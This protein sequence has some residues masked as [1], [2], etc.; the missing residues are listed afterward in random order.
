MEGALR[1]F[2]IEAFSIALDDLLLDFSK[3]VVTVETTALLENLARAARV[4][5]R[6]AAMFAGEKI[7][8]TEERA[9]LH[10]ALR[11]RS[12]RPVLVDGA[13]VMGDVRAVA[14]HAEKCTLFRNQTRRWDI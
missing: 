9:V 8:A 1:R 4:E 11:N 14:W 12:D 2:S 5:E 13:D 7:N 6:R 10:V 3:C